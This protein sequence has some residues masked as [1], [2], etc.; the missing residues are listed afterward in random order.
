MCSIS[1]SV[2]DFQ[3]AAHSHGSARKSGGSPIGCVEH[4]LRLFILGMGREVQGEYGLDKEAWCGWVS[5][6]VRVA[7]ANS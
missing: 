4:T 6:A 3:H 7:G 1:A 5:S 2:T